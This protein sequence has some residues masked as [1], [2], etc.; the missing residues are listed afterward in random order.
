MRLQG[1]QLGGIGL[2]ATL[3]VAGAL[4][5]LPATA[6]S[7]PREYEAGLYTCW[8]YGLPLHESAFDGKAGAKRVDKRWA[9]TLRRV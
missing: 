5:L 9:R 7:M 6:S 4:L 2:L 1:A 8:G 3:A